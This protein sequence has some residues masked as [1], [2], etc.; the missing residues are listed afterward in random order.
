[1]LFCHAGTVCPWSPQ[2]SEVELRGT[3]R[4]RPHSKKSGVGYLDPDPTVDRKGINYLQNHG[5]G[6]C[7]CSILILQDEIQVANKNF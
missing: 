2:A 6:P 7:T 4:E 3:N 1:M 5:V